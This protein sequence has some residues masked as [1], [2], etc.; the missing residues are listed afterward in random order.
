MGDTLALLLAKARTLTKLL[1]FLL[2]VI[3]KALCL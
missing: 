3:H 1:F 2:L